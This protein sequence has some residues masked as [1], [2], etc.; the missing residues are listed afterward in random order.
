MNFSKVAMD[1]VPQVDDIC[2]G[3]R[4]IFPQGKYSLAGAAAGTR[5]HEGV[6]TRRSSGPD[7]DL[8][9]EVEHLLKPDDGKMRYRVYT[10]TAADLK[11]SDLRL[12]PNAIDAVVAFS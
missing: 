9:F 8:L 12:S 6:V 7:G 5:Y 1:L 2:V 3:T 10:D 4:V 11:I